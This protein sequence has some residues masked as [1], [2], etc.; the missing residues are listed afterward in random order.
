MLEFATNPDQLRE[1]AISLFWRELADY[2]DLKSSGQDRLANEYVESIRL[3]IDAARPL[4]SVRSY[5]SLVRTIDGL[6]ED[7][8]T[9]A[10]CDVIDLAARRLSSEI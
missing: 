6:S 1:N 3:L 5:Y 2:R 10:P 8:F 4:I 7:N 9:S